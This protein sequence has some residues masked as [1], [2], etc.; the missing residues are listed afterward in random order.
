[1]MMER[2]PKQNATFKL[3][4]LFQENNLRIIDTFLDFTERTYFVVF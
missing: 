4:I 2:F 3:V 1:M